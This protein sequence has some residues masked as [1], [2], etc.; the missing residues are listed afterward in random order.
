MHTHTM[1]ITYI[2]TIHTYLQTYTHIYTHHTHTH[3]GALFSIEAAGHWAMTH[4]QVK[5][6]FLGIQNI[7]IAFGGKDLQYAK[8]PRHVI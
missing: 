6:G 7:Y 5:T 8:M 4:T 2:H 3:T 1:Y